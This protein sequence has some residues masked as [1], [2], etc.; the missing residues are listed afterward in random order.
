MRTLKCG[1][2]I[3]ENPE[4]RKQNKNTQ[5]NLLKI[6]YINDTKK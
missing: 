5:K 3:H 4:I 1:R 2:I 6:K